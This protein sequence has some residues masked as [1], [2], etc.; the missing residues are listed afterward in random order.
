MMPD[1]KVNIK[2]ITFIIYDKSSIGTNNSAKPKEVFERIN[3]AQ[4]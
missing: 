4:L 3:K 1:I 2:R